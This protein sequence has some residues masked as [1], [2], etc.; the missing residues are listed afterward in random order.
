MNASDKR[1]WW[2]KKRCLSVAV[3]WL[4]VAYPLTAGPYLY[5]VER[6]WLSGWGWLWDP[7][8]SMLGVRQRGIFRAEDQTHLWRCW[9]NY[10]QPFRNAGIRHRE[11]EMH[12]LDK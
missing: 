7:V 6:G 9:R 3:L 10:V 1:P 11:Y 8:P 5:C 4:F 2:R 12:A